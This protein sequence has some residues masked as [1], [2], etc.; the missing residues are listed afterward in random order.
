MDE[1]LKQLDPWKAYEV[2]FGEEPDFR[3][4]HTPREALEEF[5]RLMLMAI[6]RGTPLTEAEVDAARPPD[7]LL[8]FEPEI[9]DL[10]LL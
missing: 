6:E 3:Y 5:D 10:V 7:P 1:F 8:Q 4:F 9:R 2:K